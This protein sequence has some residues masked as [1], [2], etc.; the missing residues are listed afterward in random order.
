MLHHK[1]IATYFQKTRIDVNFENFPH[2]GTLEP[3]PGIHSCEI[4]VVH[5][6]LTTCALPHLLAKISFPVQTLR[7]QLCRDYSQHRSEGEL[8]KS[9]CAITIL[10]ASILPIWSPLV[11][12]A[13]GELSDSNGQLVVADLH[14]SGAYVTPIKVVW[15]LQGGRSVKLDLS[16]N[17]MSEGDMVVRRHTDQY[18][19]RF[20]VNTSQ[21]PW[22][23]H[24]IRKSKRQL[25][26]SSKKINGK[27]FHAPNSHDKT[28]YFLLKPILV[29]TPRDL[30]LLG[31]SRPLLIY[32]TFSLLWIA[33]YSY[34]GSISYCP[35]RRR[36]AASHSRKFRKISV[37]WHCAITQYECKTE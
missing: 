31:W 34:S 13:C 28:K 24:T 29:A 30:Q 3:F 12:L 8:F 15:R 11:D 26:Y 2:L 35:S 37:T 20:D 6:P 27:C 33:A 10:F 17:K 18:R 14:M 4:S 36:L 5:P 32:V 7:D 23:W 1:C 19:K 22:R 9:N 25:E 16:H 21:C